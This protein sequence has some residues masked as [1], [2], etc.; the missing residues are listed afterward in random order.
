M[1]ALLRHPAQ[2]AGSDGIYQGGHPHPRGWGAFARL[3]GRHVREL[4][5]WTW[6]QAASHLAGHPARRFR[7]ADR[8]LLR[9]GNAADIVVIDPN[10]VADRST[11]ERPRQLA[12]GVEHALVNG[13]VVLAGGDLSPDARQE[14]PGRA[15]RPG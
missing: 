11:Y 3:L 12:I 2:M 5:D 8:G 13:V 10:A 9:R 1:R 6:E 14:P 7:L 15:L 4:G